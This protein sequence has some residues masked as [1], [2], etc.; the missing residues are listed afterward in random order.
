[1]SWPSYIA[2]GLVLAY[3]ISETVVVNTL[4][5]TIVMAGLASALFVEALLIATI[6]KLFLLAADSPTLLGTGGFILGSTLIIPMYLL[7]AEKLSSLPEQYGISIGHAG[8]GFALLN[9]IPT[10]TSLSL[11]VVLLVAV[12]LRIVY[13][14]LPRF[15]YVP[16]KLKLLDN[17]K[18]ATALGIALMSVSGYVGADFMKESAKAM[19]LG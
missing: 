10:L 12:V 9:L 13:A 11:F 7:I 1:M 2:S 5:E 14:L 18:A 8:V 3:I 16:I 6:R 19:G 17:R 15:I 4:F